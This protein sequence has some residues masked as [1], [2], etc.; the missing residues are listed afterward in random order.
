MET[1][2]KIMIKKKEIDVYGS[3]KVL[4]LA[5]G[6]PIDHIRAAKNLAAD[7]IRTSGRIHW[8]EFGP[9]YAKNKEVVEEYIKEEESNKGPSDISEW[10]ERKERANALIAEIQLKNLQNNTLDKDSVIAFLKTISSSQAIMLRNMSQELPHRLLGKGI[11][12]MQIELSKSYDA[13]CA[14]FKS[15][16]DKWGRK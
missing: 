7:G 1:H 14:I 2:Q 3:F 10:K 4:S 15:S 11:T 12:D 8:S 13:I 6:I 9:W 5:K 16:L